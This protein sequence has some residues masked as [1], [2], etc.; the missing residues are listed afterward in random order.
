[1]VRRAAVVDQARPPGIHQRAF[2]HTRIFQSHIRRQDQ[3]HGR[4]WCQ[5]VQAGVATTGEGSGVD[6]PPRDET[7]NYLY[8]IRHDEL[9]S[10]TDW[11]SYHAIPDLVCL[12][13]TMSS[14]TLVG[15]LV[16]SHA[17]PNLVRVVSS[18]PTSSSIS[19]YPP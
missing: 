11:R 8:S 5:S 16:S 9:F 4:H 6:F 15:M 17:I 18:Y 3:S 13:N 2:G 1:M 19:Q 14:L 7:T 12:C 10:V